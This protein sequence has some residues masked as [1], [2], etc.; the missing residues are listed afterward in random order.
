MRDSDLRTAGDVLWDQIAELKAEN[1]R[2]RDA[3]WAM[4]EKEAAKH[5][6]AYEKQHKRIAELEDAAAKVIAKLRGSGG[7][8]PEGAKALLDLQALLESG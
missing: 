8:N 6:P 1:E 5:L 7:I 3:A 4:V 2:L